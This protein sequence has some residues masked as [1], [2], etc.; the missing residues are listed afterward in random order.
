MIT[1]AL[2]IRVTHIDATESYGPFHSKEI[3]P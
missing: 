2:D 1:R 3:G